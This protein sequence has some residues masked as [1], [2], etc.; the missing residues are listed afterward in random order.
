MN[1]A[2]AP[3]NNRMIVKL[4]ASIAPLPRAK[5][6][7]TELAANAINAKPV[8]KLVFSKSDNVLPLISLHHFDRNSQ[9]PSY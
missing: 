5:R 6:Q 4:D 9:H 1:R 2:T 3:D 7:S 8:S